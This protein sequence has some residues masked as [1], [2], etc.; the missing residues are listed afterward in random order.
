MSCAIYIAHFKGITITFI[1][2]VLELV[3]LADEFWAVENHVC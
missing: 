3:P 1:A 2:M